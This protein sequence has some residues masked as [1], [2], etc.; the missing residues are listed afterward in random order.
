[1]LDFVEVQNPPSP[2]EDK[3]MIRIG[4][5]LTV[6]CAAALI[7]AVAAWSQMDGVM[8]EGGSVN[9]ITVTSKS[10]NN[11]GLMP[12]DHT[13]DGKDISPALEWSNIPNNAKSIALICDDPDAP[14][15]TWIHW[16]VFNIP[17]SINGIAAGFDEKTLGPS[18]RQGNNSWNRLGYGG[19]CPPSGEHRYFFRVYAL[20]A[21]LEIKNAPNK[22][23]LLDAMKGHVLAEGD[24]MA[25]YTRPGRGG[26]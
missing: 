15:G 17:A 25:R 8:P 7:T 23:Q 9:R 1:V 5:I 18:V 21:M 12:K 16:I 19:A 22:A 11:E 24:I 10:F 26:K 14:M 20:D 2:T 13:C 6:V 4:P 3:T